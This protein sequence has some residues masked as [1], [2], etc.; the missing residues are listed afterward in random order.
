MTKLR[1]QLAFIEKLQSFTLLCLGLVVSLLDVVTVYISV[2]LMS[3]LTSTEQSLPSFIRVIVPTTLRAQVTLFAILVLARSGAKAI[4]VWLEADLRLRMYRRVATRVF[5]NQIKT[6]VTAHAKRDSA[7]SIRD[8]DSVQPYLSSYVFAP[9][10]LV[11]ES[12]LFIGIVFVLIEQSRVATFLVGALGGAVLVIVLRWSSRRLQ[13]AGQH[14]MDSSRSR[15]QFAIFS[16]RTTREF[17]LYGLENAAT[18]RYEQLLFRAITAEK[19]QELIYRFTPL[20]IETALI[21]TAIAMITTS[22]ALG[23]S[24]AETASIATVIGF[25]SFRLIPSLSRFAQA[26]QDMRFNKERASILSGYL[27]DRSIRGDKFGSANVSRSLRTPREPESSSR[28]PVSPIAIGD[29]QVRIDLVDVTYS[30]P[31]SSDKV[32]E[33]LTWSFEPGKLHVVKGPS[34]IGKSTLLSLLL[35]ITRPNS[36][37]ILINEEQFGESAVFKGRLI[38]YVPQVVSAIDQSISENIA[39]SF[40]NPALVDGERLEW[41]VRTAGLSDFV[42]GQASGLESFIGESGARVS[43]GQL[44]RIGIAR[45]LYRKPKVL[46]LDEVTS[47]L[48]PLTEEQLLRDFGSIKRETLIILVSHSEQV[49]KY[50]DKVLDLSFVKVSG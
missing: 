38:A 45:A 12:L 15:L 43:G 31:D 24:G 28:K 36:G 29:S 46:L 30:Y 3:S 7:E 9:L 41:A 8:L 37:E 34:G 48:D 2:V 32:L 22:L 40:G 1:P 4:R 33:N 5:Y 17:L 39:L 25:G 16:F 49:A 27:K 19:Q 42:A 21:F 14:S 50:A 47:N 11:E 35:G 23:Q 18:K 26:L 10:S 6:Q 44:Q 13:L 20:F